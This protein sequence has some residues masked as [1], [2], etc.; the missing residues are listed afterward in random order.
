MLL[1]GRHTMRSCMVK[2]VQQDSSHKHHSNSRRSS[3]SS[4]KLLVPM[5]RQQALLLQHSHSLVSTYTVKPSVLL[6]ILI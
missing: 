4:S 6:A 1:R 5:G 2:P 3:S